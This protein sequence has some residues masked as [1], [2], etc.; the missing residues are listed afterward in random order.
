MDT[1]DT[2]Q[3]IKDDIGGKMITLLNSIHGSEYFTENELYRMCR[4]N[5]FL[6]YKTNK[7]LN[8]K[9]NFILNL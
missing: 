9:R 6:K 7:Y 4:I 8:E 2:Y 1:E 3:I 5:D